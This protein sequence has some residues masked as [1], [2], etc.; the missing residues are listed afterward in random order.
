MART[1]RPKA[2]IVLID[3]ERDQLQRWARRRTSAQALRSRTVLACAGGSDNESVAAELGCS[4]AT[5]G[6]WRARLIDA[7]LDDDPRP[8]RLNSLGRPIQRINGEG[9]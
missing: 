8:G 4:A 7:R 9:R 2:E 5:V 3:E 1:G 6:K